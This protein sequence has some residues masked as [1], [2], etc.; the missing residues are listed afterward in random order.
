MAALTRTLPSPALPQQWGGSTAG[1]AGSAQA[2]HSTV[3]DARL[4]HE[5]C[6]AL[7]MLALGV[8]L[9]RPL[10][11][12]HRSRALPGRAGGRASLTA[13]V[14]KQATVLSP[15]REV[16][17]PQ[18]RSQ[19]LL[20]TLPDAK[21]AASGAGSAGSYAGL[22]GIDRAWAK[23][24]SSEPP[25]APP[26]FVRELQD[27]LA[28]GETA[29]FDVVVCGGTLGIFVAAALQRRGLQ[30]C[31]LERGQLAG[32]AQE[33]NISLKEMQDLVAAG[34]LDEEDIDGPTEVPARSEVKRSSSSSDMIA[35]HY[36][37][38]RAG[39]NGDEFGS[40]GSGDP[41][42]QEVWLGDILNAGI[43]P[44]VAVERAR[45]R[46]E[47][48]GGVVHEGVGV[49]SVDVHSNA[50][51]LHL[52]SAGE[53]VAPRS[54]TAKLV[55]DAMGNQSPISRQAR[56]TMRPFGIC[57]VVGSLASG[58]DLDNSFGDLIYTNSDLWTGDVPETDPDGVL[59]SPRKQYYWEA[60]PAGSGLTDRTTYLFTYMDAEAERPSIEQQ[61]EDY[62]DLLPV[63]QRHNCRAF[64]EGKT[65]EEAVASGDVQLKRVLYGCFP[66]YKDS[67]LPPVSARVLAV[68]DASGIQSPLSFGGFGAL[69][70]HIKRISD[71]V[72][73]AIQLDAL[74]RED[75]SAV[76]AYLPN[77]SATWMFQRSM[78]VPLGD[79][80]PQNFVNRLLRT[81]FQIMSD[82]GPEIL[83]PFNQDVVQPRAL[84]RVLLEATRR[85]PWNIPQL[86]YYIGPQLLLEWLGHMT[87]MFA[88]D[89]AHNF[90]SEPLLAYAAQL[91]KGGDRKSAF[92]L[93]R[94][95][96]QWEFGSGQD[97]EL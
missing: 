46:F 51:K 56:G 83:K 79:Q 58:F 61:L 25:M 68:G 36:G 91:E 82:F 77:Q 84:G 15:E 12:H 28:N 93:K 96:E 37:S 30:V 29:Q 76:N 66:T 48:S 13:V 7:P 22:Q 67:P 52:A 62:W 16:P 88:F 97:Y 47:A 92:R 9:L 1:S 24:R 10:C 19:R 44:A 81:N 65:V 57:I 55:I 70:R 41:R 42:L 27:P 90:L 11:K 86:C 5:T 80:R 20:A 72:V 75:L 49:T 60:F 31:V 71:A 43:R 39:F 45:K 87:A 95:A 35:I 63:Y 73:D 8:G 59:G 3:G 78:M 17:L 94:L 23:V 69:T 18:S 89:F 38:V 6:T 74:S 85:D 64:A 53:Q 34:A 33:W 50:A 2:A 26:D 40:S 21:D 32:R 54:I 14:D 4:R